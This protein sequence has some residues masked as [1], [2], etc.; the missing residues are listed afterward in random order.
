MESCQSGSLGLGL[1]SPLVLPL[2]TCLIPYW[3]I[4]M[5][6]MDQRKYQGSFIWISKKHLIP[7]DH[8]TL[9]KKLEHYGLVWTELGW[10]KSYLT[11]RNQVIQID[12]ALSVSRVSRVPHGSIVG[13]L[14]FS[15]YINDITSVIKSQV[16]LYADDT[17]LFHSGT[18][19]NSIQ[20]APS[21]PLPY[22]CD[23]MAYT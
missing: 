11:G 23:W 18:D 20:T 13:P 2:R 15:M 12:D 3:P 6:E 8:G 22:I 21:E 19:V 16:N 17:A 1:D 5:V 9:L 4:W 14:L 7:V 10:L